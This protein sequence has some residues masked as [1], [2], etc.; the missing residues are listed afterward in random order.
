[1]IDF[2]NE[3]QKELIN[4]PIDEKYIKK[5]DGLSYVSHSI[6]TE[7]L[8][9]IFGHAW[10]WE[11]LDHGIEASRTYGK[12]KYGTQND[13]QS[14]QPESYYAWVLGRLTIPYIVNNEVHMI[15]KD[16]FGG[17]FLVGAAKVQCQAFKSASSDA[18][19]KAASL[20]G[21]AKNVYMDEE[22]YEGLLSDKINADS[23]NDTNVV[24]Y[25]NEI[26]TINA[27]KE[28]VGDKE[29]DAVVNE[30]CDA[31]QKYTVYGK[32][33]PSNIMDVIEFIHKY[34]PNYVASEKKN[35]VAKNLFK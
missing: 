22:S 3:K 6:M 27:I 17:K 2:I 5:I 15:S 30:F 8:N 35:D 18:L 25:R 24:Q 34:H 31:T 32:I 13:N 12:K 21:I 10:S 16:A 23:W 14:Q 19:K 1:M 26:Q 4:K 33:T 29:L 28:L 7:Q 11:I 20:F 9:T